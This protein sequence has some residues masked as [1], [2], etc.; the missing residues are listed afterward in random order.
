MERTINGILWSFEPNRAT[1]F[2]N[3]KLI[4]DVIFRHQ[5][6][7]YEVRYGSDYARPIAIEY[8]N[9]ISY[10]VERFGQIHKRVN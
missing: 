3:D 1:A 5:C 7:M 8:V 6:G 10:G 2:V 9:T 4:G